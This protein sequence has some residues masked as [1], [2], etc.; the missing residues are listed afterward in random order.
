MQLFKEF[1]LRLS[2]VK[3]LP[4]SLVNI[5]LLLN[6]KKQNKF[7]I[8]KDNILEEEFLTKNDKENII[9]FIYFSCKTYE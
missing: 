9:R 5:F 8:F 1:I 7:E 3:N 6:W 4:S 2:K